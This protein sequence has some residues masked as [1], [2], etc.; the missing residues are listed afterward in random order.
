MKLIIKLGAA[1][2]V[3][4][5][6]GAGGTFAAMHFLHLG[7]KTPQ[8]AAVLPP[9]PILFADLAI[10]AT[11]IAADAGSDGSSF[12]TLDIQFVTTDPKALASFSSLQPIITAAVLNLL[13]SET[14]TQLRDPTVKATLTAN[15]LA[16]TNSI[17]LKNGYPPPAPFTAGYITKLVVQD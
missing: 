14:S 9:K 8:K 15:S 2:V 5:V 10:D 3:V 7:S 11:S 1:V 16:L 17:L 13:G 12:A 6:L 4:A